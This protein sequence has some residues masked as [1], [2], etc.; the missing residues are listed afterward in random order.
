MDMDRRRS[1]SLTH[2]SIVIVEEAVENTSGRTGRRPDID[3]TDKLRRIY[4]Q[5]SCLLRYEDIATNQSRIVNITAHI[6]TMKFNVIRRCSL[7]TPEAV[8]SRELGS[9]KTG[10]IHTLVEF[11]FRSYRLSDH[12]RG[13]AEGKLEEKV[14]GRD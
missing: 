2:S 8:E 12:S 13:L 3:K 4:G 9:F 10:Y 11:Q 1:N 6:F 5:C 14:S 7:L